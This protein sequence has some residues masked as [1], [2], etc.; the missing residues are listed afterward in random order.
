MKARRAICSGI[1]LGRRRRGDLRRT[2]PSKIVPL[3]YPCQGLFVVNASAPPLPDFRFVQN[4]HVECA[5]FVERHRVRSSLLLIWLVHMIPCI[6]FVRFS[7][8]GNDGQARA[9]SHTNRQAP[10]S[11]NRRAASLCT[12]MYSVELW[13]VLSSEGIADRATVVY[14]HCPCLK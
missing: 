11:A 1:V 10:P 8:E 6:L 9:G 2:L 14:D 5:V 12:G 3:S 7:V 13:R 4:V